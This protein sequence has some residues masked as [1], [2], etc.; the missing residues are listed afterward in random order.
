MNPFENPATAVLVIVT[1]VVMV[2]GMGVLILLLRHLIDAVETA[3]RHLHA[4]EATHNGL[5]E[6][7]DRRLHHIDSTT[8]QLT[9]AVVDNARRSPEAVVEQLEQI[10]RQYEDLSA[11]VAVGLQYTPDP[12]KGTYQAGAA[13]AIEHVRSHVQAAL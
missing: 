1:V 3:G 9:V 6:V 12:E 8:A 4:M 10:T 2:A 7:L 5:R 11:A 13:E